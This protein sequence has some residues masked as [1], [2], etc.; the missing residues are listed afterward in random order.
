MSKNST[1]G[2]CYLVGAGPGDPGL[3]TLRGCE[4]LKR[5]DVVIYDYLSNPEL[6]RYAPEAAERIY[7]G[8]IAGQH[9]IHQKET[10]ALLIKFTRAGKCVAGGERKPQPSPRQGSALKSCQ[11]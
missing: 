8:K 10:N 1:E 11:G 9:A 3:L 2:I 7:A 5:A 4:C 6:L